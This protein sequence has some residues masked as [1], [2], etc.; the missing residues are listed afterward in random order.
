M[1]FQ[2]NK[3]EIKKLYDKIKVYYNIIL[4]LLPALFVP[5]RV[6]ATPIHQRI[7]FGA[8]AGYGMYRMHDVNAL[9]D[10]RNGLFIMS[11]PVELNPGHITGGSNWHLDLAFGF[12]PYLLAGI[13]GG[14]LSAYAKGREGNILLDA[15]YY[16]I[17]ITA[18]ELGGFIKGAWPLGE[19][20][21]LTGGF[22]F[23]N[24][25]LAGFGE[26]LDNRGF[27]GLLLGTQQI[28]YS[29]SAF[30][31]KLMIGVDAFVFP[32]FAIAL[33]SGY[34]WARIEEVKGEINGENMVLKMSN[35]DS[36]T[37]DFSGPFVKAGC[38][39]YF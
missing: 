20:I 8:S 11:I 23:Y 25:A 6:M 22:G 15:S 7:M 37:V 18:R 4:F 32:T 39:I 16:D 5:S 30:G 21:L 1:I 35:G 13:E 29:G 17:D 28:P 2:L 38:R 33:E 36:F 9:I 34:R 24:V 31:Q 3:L 19:F 26:R 27:L 12:L 14:G 10:E